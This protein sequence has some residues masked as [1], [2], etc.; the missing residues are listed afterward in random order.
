MLMSTANQV[1]VFL[2]T[3]Y[4]GMV[5]G[6]IYDLNRVFRW[7]FKPRPW[8]VGIMDL[9]F[10]LVVAA[11]VFVALLYANDGEV[12]FYNFVGLAI[13][14]SLYLLTISPWVI[15]ALTLIYRVIEKGVRYIIRFA[16]WPLRALFNFFNKISEKIRA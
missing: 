10:W 14:W 13:G 2:A 16:S 3:V 15:K 11:L 7:T 4:A 8:V 1:Y 12:R 9:F 5:V 6:F